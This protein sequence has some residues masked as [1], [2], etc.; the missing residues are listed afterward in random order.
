MYTVVDFK[1]SN[2]I[3]LI[4]FF[5][6]YVKP[7][8]LVKIAEKLKWVM[9]IKLSDVL[10]FS[11]VWFHYDQDKNG[12]LE[13][14]EFSKFM[15]DLFLKKDCTDITPKEVFPFCLNTIMNVLCPHC[16]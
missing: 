1:V 5:I 9:G 4:Y 2:M 13:Y 6:A 15:K 7:E 3:M 11:Q 10:S 8:N 12:Y 14:V 16:L